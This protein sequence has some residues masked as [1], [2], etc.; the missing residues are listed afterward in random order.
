MWPIIGAG[1]RND[2][3][4]NGELEAQLTLTLAVRY[5]YD[6]METEWRARATGGSDEIFIDDF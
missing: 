5:V 2:T 3:M 6:C 1:L 4:K